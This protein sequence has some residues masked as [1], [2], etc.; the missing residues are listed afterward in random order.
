M[1]SL[2]S[3]HLLL[4]AAVI[5]GSTVF[6]G[7]PEQ[8][9]DDQLV[10]HDCL[11]QNNTWSQRYYTSKKYFKGPGHPIICIIGGEGPANDIFYPFITDYL[12]KDL[13]A[14]VLEPEHRFYGKSLPVNWTTSAKDPRQTLFT[15]KQALQDAMRLVKSYQSKLGCSDD[16]TSDAYCPVM[17]V[18]GSYPGWLSAMARLIFPET[19]DMAYSASAPMKFYS[20]EVGAS[21]YYDH[22]TKVADKTKPGCADSVGFTLD[23]VND[24]ILQSSDDHVDSL[25]YLLGICPNT[26]PKY[27]STS[28]MFAQEVMMMIG[29]T[30]ANLNMGAY[31]PKSLTNSAPKLFHACSAFTNNQKDEP[32]QRV[33]NFLL[34]YIGKNED[35]CLD[36]STQMPTGPNATISGGD[37]SGDGWGAAAESWDFQTCTL[38]VEKIGFSSESMFPTRKW[39]MDWMKEHCMSRFGVTPQPY[40]L[41]KEW[42]FDD[43]TL[44]TN[45]SRILFTNGLNDGWSVGGIQQNLSE[46]IVALNFPNGAHHSD[47]SHN[48]PSWHDSRDIKEGY[49]FVTRLFSQWLNEMKQQQRQSGKLRVPREQEDGPKSQSA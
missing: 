49:K 36:M 44:K 42:G 9:Y 18:G 19:V 27:I 21:D 40:K 47:L 37:W 39:T 22:I 23:I 17:T 10:D 15:S 25:A 43:L 41:V 33:K 2:S 29:Y 6:G 3:A 46:T 28:E 35:G 4:I 24:W 11:C 7:F 20:Q 32:V 30:F 5:D 34:E 31:P 13:G 38:L 12:A 16:K 26:V 14:F 8:F 1:N 48:G 45:A